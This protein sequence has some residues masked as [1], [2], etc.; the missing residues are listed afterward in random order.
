ML[1]G[2]IIMMLL[3]NR[4]LLNQSMALLLLLIIV[5]QVSAQKKAATMTQF[6]YQKAWVEVN[7]FQEKGLPESALKAVNSIYDQA[8][9]EGR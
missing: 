4:R 1:I 6:H 5:T 9:K 8:K 2:K 7:Q 3:D